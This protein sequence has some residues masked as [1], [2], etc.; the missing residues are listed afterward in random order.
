MKGNK[1]NPFC[2]VPDELQN[3]KEYTKFSAQYIPQ[4]ICFNHTSQT[5]CKVTALLGPRETDSPVLGMDSAPLPPW[6]H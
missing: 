2:C 3:K 5:H 1:R 4:A 6:L